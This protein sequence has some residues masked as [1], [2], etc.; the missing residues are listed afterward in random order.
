MRGFDSERYY[1]TTDPELELLGSPAALARQRSIGQGPKYL[2]VGRRILYRGCDLIAYLEQCV[3]E[4][5][6][7]PRGS[8]RRESETD[9][10]QVV[11][12]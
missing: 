9:A 5:T 1:L 12:A 7:G 8:Q 6:V 4:P 10:G 3:V 11:P 2:K